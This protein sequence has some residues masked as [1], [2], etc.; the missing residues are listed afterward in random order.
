MDSQIR[1]AMVWPGTLRL[2]HWVIAFT[3]IALVISGW[4]LRG[5]LQDNMNLMT[6]HLLS[7]WLLT[8]A[9]L[10][11]LYRLFRGQAVESW[12]A[13]VPD[14]ATRD[15]RAGMIRF[16]FSFGRAPL[17]AYYAHNPLWGP[18]YLALFVLLAF[19]AATGTALAIADPVHRLYYEATPWLFGFTL[20]QWHG[21]IT[22]VLGTFAVVHI[23]AVVLHELRG[24][25]GEVSAMI[26]GYK[27]FEPRKVQLD[28]AE[29]VSPIQMP[30]RQKNR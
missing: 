24:T 15:A 9:L 16:Y 1:R 10:F 29:G 30:P 18:V 21:S 28:L 19:G 17:P 11:R 5:G 8:V 13:L 25:G 23:F 7:G 22:K 4:A 3:T 12:R 2:A 26:N 27:Y 20:P 6:G 14:M